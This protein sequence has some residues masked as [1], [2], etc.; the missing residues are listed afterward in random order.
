M[1]LST[2]LQRLG[3]WILL[4][5]VFVLPWFFL[6]ITSDF[7][8]FNKNILLILSSLSLLLIWAITSVLDRQ[9]RIVRSPLGLPLLAIVATWIAGA[10]LRSPNRVEAFLMPG[11][12]GT[13]IALA[14]FFFAAVNF[15]RTK[16]DVDWLIISLVGSLSLL[17]LITLF[18][19]SGAILALIPTLTGYLNSPVWNPSG[20][21]LSAGIAF[22][23]GLPLIGFLVFKHRK[24]A[25]SGVLALA[26][27]LLI[28]A[29][30]TIIYRLMFPAALGSSAVF[31]P[32]NS[33]WGIALEALKSSPLL[34]TG[35]ATFLSD[36]TRFR[37]ISFN[38]T[39]SW[40][41]RFVASSNYYLQLLATGGILGLAAYLFLVMRTYRLVLKGNRL[42]NSSQAS[43]SHAMAMAS[44][45]S[46][47]ACFG[48]QLLLPINLVLLFLTVVYLIILIGALK[49]AGTTTVHEASVDIVAA[50][51]GN[52]SPLLPWVLLVLVLA[53]CGVV[54]YLGGRAYL[55]EVMYQKALVSATKN[56]GRS[57]YNQL[58]SAISYN[59][60]IDTYRVTYSRT[61]L[62]LASSVA[63]NPNLKDADRTVI[64]QL[65]QQGIREAKNA[66]GLNGLK[67]SNV[68]NLATVY[69]NL[70]N[71][72][73]G[74]DA[75]TV[76]SYRQA[77]ALDPVNPNLRIALGGVLYSQKNYDDAIR[78]FQQAADLKPDLANAHYN[79]A[80]AY[81][82]RGDLQKAIAAMQNVVQ[83]VNNNSDDY[84]K[85][86]AELQE[87]QKKAGPAATT[88]ATPTTTSS[89]LQTP[90]PL[91]SP[92]INPPLELDQSLSPN[93]TPEPT[94]QP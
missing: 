57:T 35:P 46:A 45:L 82:E 30:S 49:L 8:E 68:E 43:Y 40:N 86:N 54:G 74:A 52:N 51:A 11:Q 73:E 83:L 61:N 63:T 55:A 31:L 38:L 24:Q 66:V 4:V 2:A 89:E 41:M 64:S 90:E 72:A 78:F 20:S 65:V 27:L 21:L 26:L 15:V 60:F 88:P 56:D 85:A 71:F 81:R 6:P 34:G 94:L 91:P 23:T 75:W 44:G 47:L 22:A 67:V 14:A 13:W 62:L 79:L 25:S 84:Q 32:F 93:I 53:T 92:V 33:G 76:A 39:S 70:L 28:I 59:P 3:F 87:L 10:V 58:V 9:V 50:G 1:S 17:G 16:K 42:A 37:P 7:Y 80:A 77:I 69:R 29:T 36:F 19:S 12:T 5:T 18:W 48:L